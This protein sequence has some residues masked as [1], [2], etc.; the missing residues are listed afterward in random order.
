MKNSKLSALLSGKKILPLLL[1]AAALGVLL[2]VFGG[3]AKKTS[4]GDEFS[5]YISR[6][7]NKIEQTVSAI[8]GGK[9]YVIVT[10]DRGKAAEYAK[11]K[12]ENSEQTVISSSGPVTEYTVYPTVRGISVVCKN[13]DDATVRRRITEALACAYGIST[14]KIYVA[15]IK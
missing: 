4:Q 8:C 1:C 10:A 6:T 11:N 15:P 14:S 7:E 5:E 3:G 13:G 2:M 9:A 12:S